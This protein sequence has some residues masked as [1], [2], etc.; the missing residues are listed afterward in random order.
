M[1]QVR[2][3]VDQLPAGENAHAFLPMPGLSAAGSSH[4]EV[5]VFGAWG[6]MPV[7]SPHPATS[8]HLSRSPLLRTP[9]DVAPDYFCP[10][11]GIAGTRNMRPPVRYLPNHSRI[12]APAGAIADQPSPVLMRGRKIGTRWSMIWPR[13]VTRWPNILDRPG[14]GSRPPEGSGGVQSA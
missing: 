1:A 5:D 3:R 12:P 13:V 9:S 2:Y 6:T 14:P 11:I 7:P 4:G 8:P 10:Q